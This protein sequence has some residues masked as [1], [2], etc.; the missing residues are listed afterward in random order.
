MSQLLFALAF[1]VGLFWRIEHV[2]GNKRGRPLRRPQMRTA[3]ALEWVNQEL[4]PA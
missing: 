4:V 2:C 1:L 3:N